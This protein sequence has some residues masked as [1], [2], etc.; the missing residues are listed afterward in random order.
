MTP[1]PT[2]NLALLKPDAN[3]LYN[4]SVFNGNVDIIDTIG[5][6]TVCTSI[7]RPATPYP[8]QPIFETDTDLLRVWVPGSPGAWSTLDPGGYAS[9]VTAAT[10]PASPVQGRIIY[11]T[12]TGLMQYWDSTG[13]PQWRPLT[14]SN[15]GSAL[16]IKGGKRYTTPATLATI[17]AAEA[18]AG[19]DTG[20][21]TLEANTTYR[22]DVKVEVAVSIATTN[23]LLRIRDTN[24]AGAIV[25]TFRLPN[26]VV[27]T[28]FHYEFSTFVLSP[29]AGARTYVLT[30]Q[31]DVGTPS[32]TI[33][34]TSGIVPHMTIEKVGSN[35]LLTAV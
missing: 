4:I 19:M 18:L 29:S 24:L 22:I 28:K 32:I 16:G 25:S 11:E 12:D 8:Y 27:T 23:A 21:I 10:R 15:L 26:Q 13:S 2:T 14:Y 30:A 17:T 5:R 20:S 33:T 7:T 31:R 34:S 1:T 3:D 35:T 9:I 6:I